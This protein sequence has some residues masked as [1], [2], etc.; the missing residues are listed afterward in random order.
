MYVPFRPW[1]IMATRT[2]FEAHQDAIMAG[3]GFMVF[4]VMLAT[5][6]CLLRRR[7]K[8]DAAT[9]TQKAI[10]EVTAVVDGVA[11]DGV[12]VAD[13]DGSGVARLFLSCF[14]AIYVMAF[15]S[16][17]L[18]Y[19]G[20]FGKGGLAPVEAYWSQVHGQVRVSSDSR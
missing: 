7:K 1:I 8:P 6:A 14:G 10:R 13:D 5:V 16:Y 3:G 20:L 11:G 19:P 9:V 2:P 15:A 17:Y 18:Q 12:A 4:V